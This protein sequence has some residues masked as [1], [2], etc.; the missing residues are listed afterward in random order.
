MSMHKE[1]A[2]EDELCDYLEQHGW[3]Y[4]RDDTGYDREL[5]M[6]PADV[7]GWLE[8]TQPEALA[9]KVKASDPPAL[10][11]KSRQRI[12]ARL[13]QVLDKPFARGGGTLTVLRRG[14][15]DVS[16][17][18]D[19]CQFKPAQ[20]LNAATLQRYNSVRLRV[21]RQVR[22]SLSNGNSIDLVLFVN[23]LPVATMELKT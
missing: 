22:Y 20:Q 19:L 23:G 21:M 1:I 4:S 16:T 11:E 9:Q 7:L 6:F 18:F 8:Q 10:Q 13:A 14:F 2:F 5:A 12:L 15:K 17:Q 3:L